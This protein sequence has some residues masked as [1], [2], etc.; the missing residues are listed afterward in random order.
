MGE[1]VGQSVNMHVHTDGGSTHIQC[2]KTE[3]LKAPAEA[4]NHV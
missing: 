1:T 4:S 2:F 3:A